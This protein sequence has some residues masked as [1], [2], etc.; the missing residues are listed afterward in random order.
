DS[1]REGAQW[2][3]E[4][5]PAKL[6]TPQTSR[7]YRISGATKS[8]GGG[9]SCIG[10]RGSFYTQWSKSITLTVSSPPKP[11]VTLQPSWTQ[12]Y[13]GEIYSGETVTVRCEIQGGEGAQWTYEWRRGQVNIRPTS[14]EYTISRATESDSGGYS[15]RGRRG[16]SWTEWSDIT[17]LNVLSPPKPTVTLQPSWTQIYSG[18][19]VTVRC[20]IQGVERAQWTYEWRRG[21]SSIHPTSS[22][23]TIRVTESDGGGYSCRA[24]RSSSWTEWSD[25]TTLRVTAPPKPTVT[26]QPSWTQIYSGETVT[27]RCEIQGGEGAQWTYEWRPAKL[28]TPPTSSEYK[29]IRATKSHVGGYSCRGRRSSSWTEW[30]DITTLTV[31]SPPKPTVTLQPS[32]TQIYSSETVTVRCEIQGGEGA[33]WTYEWTP[34]K[35]NTPPTSNEYRITVTESDSGG[36]SCRG[37]RDYLLTYWSDIITLTVSCKL[38]T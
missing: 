7:E 3:Y 34:A 26:L 21:Q 24:T 27:V 2:T 36:Y 19:R 32:W 16:S 22:V 30:S 15:C 6:N 29:I 9:Y 20:E 14:S 11:T 12:I 1:G 25:I 18:D 31:L 35:L 8:D 10:R 23:Y 33:Q 37:R 17:T 28:N 5:R 4:W 13:S 38:I